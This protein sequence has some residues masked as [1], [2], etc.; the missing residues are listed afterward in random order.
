[1]RDSDAQ[2]RNTIACLACSQTARRNKLTSL[3]LDECCARFEWR[4]RV[5][6]EM[7]NEEF[8][9]LSEE[10]KGGEVDWNESICTSSWCHS[11]RRRLNNTDRLVDQYKAATPRRTQYAFGLP[12]IDDEVIAKYAT[13]PQPA[14]HHEARIVYCDGAVNMESGQTAR[15]VGSSKQGMERIRQHWRKIILNARDGEY[16]RV[17]SRKEWQ[18]NIRILMK[19]PRDVH[20]LFSYDAEAKLTMISGSLDLRVAGHCYRPKAA[21]D[22]VTRFRDAAGL[23]LSTAIPLNHAFQ[24]RQSISKETEN[25]VCSN[26]KGTKDSPHLALRKALPGC[27]VAAACSILTLEYPKTLPYLA[28]LD[29]FTQ[30]SRR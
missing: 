13:R 6:S 10:E 17:V 23:V 3:C 19:F 12:I 30:Q 5:S 25:F 11:S 2:K 22:F 1:M 27:N 16:Y 7:F 4:L 14:L 21:V 9:K 8:N 20:P 29:Y 26:C 15:Y 24:P 18:S 28:Q